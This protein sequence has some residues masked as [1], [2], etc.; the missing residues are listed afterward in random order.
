MSIEQLRPLKQALLKEYG[1]FSDQRVKKIDSGSL[2]IVDNRTPSD[3]GADRKLYPWFCLIFAEVVEPNAVVVTMRGG[4]PRSA[5]VEKW[6]KENRADDEKHGLSFAVTPKDF[7]KL[8]ALAKAVRSI[9]QGPYPVKAY[10]YVC[11]RT[12]ASLERL[13]SALSK[14]WSTGA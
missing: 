5:A 9:V 4:I 1:H 14:H 3:H 2:L 11:P 13:H 6:I 8:T 10:K 12:A 7:G